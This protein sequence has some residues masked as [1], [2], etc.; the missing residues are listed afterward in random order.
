MA[1]RHVKSLV[2]TSGGLT[3]QLYPPD[4]LGGRYQHSRNVVLKI[5]VF[6][7][8]TG[9]A[10][11][12][13]QPYVAD[14]LLNQLAIRTQRIWFSDQPVWLPPNEASFAAYV[15]ASHTLGVLPLVLHLRE[16]ML[17]ASAT[18]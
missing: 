18:A 1:S 10:N 7:N 4:E 14:S 9:M 11:S 6:A 2:L 5:P 12:F 16:E 15:K 3:R 13:F 8:D 17:S